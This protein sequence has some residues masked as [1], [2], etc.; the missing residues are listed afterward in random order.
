VS[1]RRS[2]LRRVTGLLVGILLA[3]GSSA[4]VTDVAAGLWGK[5]KGYRV[6]VTDARGEQALRKPARQV[7]ALDW[8]YAENLLALGLTP[9]AVVDPD[10]YTA[11]VGAGP[12][13]PNEVADA[14]TSEAPD[15]AAIRDVHPDL[16]ITARRPPGR[17]S[18]LR[19]VAPVLVFDPDRTDMSAWE[20][21]RTT[22]QAIGTAVGR[23]ARAERVLGQLDA[24]MAKS[25]AAL[26]DAGA[27]ELPLAIMQGSSSQGVPRLRIFARGSL[28][29]D[30]TRQLGLKNAWRGRPLENGGYT[31]VEELQALEPVGRADVVYVAPVRDNPFGSMLGHEAEWTALDFVRTSRVH[32]LGARTYYSGGPLSMRLYAHEVVKALT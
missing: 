21:M 26:S 1:V 17:I 11:S 24:T 25:R 30:A 6:T 14:G 4:C 8:A 2:C 20:E 27:G 29:S 9:A 32:G 10:G 31:R 22:F 3:M 7:V 15:L 19:E 5:P 23:S 13:L 28:V 16:I 18:Q 12:R